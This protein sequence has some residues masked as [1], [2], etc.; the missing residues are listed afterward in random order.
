MIKNK[1]FVNIWSIYEYTYTSKNWKH[2]LIKRDI[3]AEF[4]FQALR[5]QADSQK[6]SAQ[7]IYNKISLCNDRTYTR[8]I[9]VCKS[10]RAQAADSILTKPPSTWLH[11]KWR[12]R[13]FMVFI[14]WTVSDVLL[15]AHVTK[16]FNESN[17]GHVVFFW[18]EHDARARLAI[19]C[20]GM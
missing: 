20:T 11:Q 7:I 3:S 1:A 19:T 8:G 12:F 13:E 15:A 4:A 6:L 18:K 9:I 10:V 14:S 5:K 16:I 2:T 17:V